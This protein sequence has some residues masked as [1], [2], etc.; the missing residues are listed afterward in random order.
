MIDN[1]LWYRSCIQFLSYTNISRHASAFG[2]SRN[3]CL[4]GY[5]IE[6]HSQQLFEDLIHAT[7]EGEQDTIAA[8]GVEG[9]ESAV[10]ET[11]GGLDEGSRKDTGTAIA[12][13]H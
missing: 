3:I 10:E 7:N 9:T 13:A 12:T 1:G 6:R 8:A 5:R 2:E 4:K 11:E